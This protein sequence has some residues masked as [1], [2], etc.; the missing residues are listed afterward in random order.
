MI[1]DETAGFAERYGPWAVIAGGSEGVGAEFARGL[2][3]RGVNV[4]LLARRQAAL[5]QVAAVIRDDTG[6]EVRSVVVDL[7][8]DDAVATIVAATDD[9]D[10]GLL[11]YCAGADPNYRHFLDEPIESALSMVQRNCVVPMRLCHHFA[12]PMVARGSGS[13]VLVSSGGGLVGAPNMVAYGATK[14]FDMVMAEALWAEL[15]GQGVD[16]L[17]MVLGLTDTPALR[18]LMVERG[19]L[20][21]VDDSVPGAASAA[22]VAAG[23]MANLGN[24]PT[25]IAG[26]DVRAG[27]E[28]LGGMP[29]NDAVRL[30]AQAAGGTMGDDPKAADS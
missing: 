21:S 29:R 16:V 19:R 5:D 9:L 6:V 4:V 25:W 30:M 1:A 24:G 22:T 10:V 2:A 26:D 13:I 11:M 15:H 17:G 23:A 7:A 18:R 20:A 28:H 3:E 27:L 12:A 8:E 14:A